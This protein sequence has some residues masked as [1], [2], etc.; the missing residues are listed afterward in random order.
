MNT[1]SLYLWPDSQE[2]VG[3]SDCF[4]YNGENNPQNED[5]DFDMSLS[6]AIF[7]PDEKGDYLLLDPSA[8]NSLIPGQWGCS[9]DE[10]D[11]PKLF[12]EI[13]GWGTC[14]NGDKV[15]RVEGGHFVK[16]S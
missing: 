4:F 13:L 15:A 16:V 14:L 12:V 8:D 2:F 10:D 3:R 7:V 11:S 6:Q 9:Y 1:Y 5:D